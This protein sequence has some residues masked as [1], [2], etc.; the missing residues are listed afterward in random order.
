MSKLLRYFAP[1]HIYFVTSVTHNRAPI[2]NEH[3]DL[4]M[5]SIADLQ[6]KIKFELNAWVVMPDHFHLV[7][8]PINSSLDQVMKRLKLSFA[9]KYRERRRI[10][11][12]QVWQSRYWDHI[13]R[14]QEDWNRHIDYI[15]YNP[16]KHGLAKSPFIWKHSSIHDYL[17][18]GFYAADWG[19]KGDLEFI[20]DWGE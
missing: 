8:D 11:S 4:F 5:H 14:N 9:F 20:G 10:Q 1:G 16:V 7:I 2:L 6:D 15:H 17:R 12:G 13:I 18:E 19:V 3:A